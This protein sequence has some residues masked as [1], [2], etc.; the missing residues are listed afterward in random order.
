MRAT[1]LCFTHLL[2]LSLFN[3]LIN[4]SFGISSVGGRLVRTNCLPFLW[5]HLVLIWCLFL[6]VFRYAER[7]E[8]TFCSFDASRAFRDALTRFIFLF[9]IVLNMHEWMT[10]TDKK[11]IAIR[12]C[13]ILMLLY[14]SKKRDNFD[15]KL[16]SLMD[17][18]G[19][20]RSYSLRHHKMPLETN[21]LPRYRTYTC[22]MIGDA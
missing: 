9:T 19:G 4:K 1:I 7:S 14:R 17:T 6:D 22:S 21:M 12:T 15:K 13:W 18:P 16:D 2:T 8:I 10:P 3:M 20:E 11:W 5:C